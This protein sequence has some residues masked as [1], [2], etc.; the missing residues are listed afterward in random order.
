MRLRARSGSYNR[1]PS[2]SRRQ[3]FVDDALDLG[4]SPL[5]DP[6]DRLFRHAPSTIMAGSSSKSRR[7]ARVNGS[8]WAGGY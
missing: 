3:R 7:R 2:S 1:E 4:S 6:R 8:G 5:D